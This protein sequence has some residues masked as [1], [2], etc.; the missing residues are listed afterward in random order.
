MEHPYQF[1]MPLIGL[2]TGM[3]I[4]EVCQLYISD[5]K[6]ID[7][8]WCLDINADKPGKSVKNSE[9]RIVPLHSFLI[10]DLNFVG[11]VQ[12]LPDR[13]GRIFPELEWLKDR[14]SRRAGPWFS[15]FKDRC[16]VVAESG[17]KAFHGFRHTVMDHL[18]Q[19]DVPDRTIKMFVGHTITGETGGR[20]GK[21]FEPKLLYEKVVQ[22]LGLR[23]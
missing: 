17:S 20:Y 13:D 6:Q 14:Y 23:S 15:K 11:F 2:Y 7:G 5:L 4:N 1:W 21:R 16:G 8:I 10:D 12:S 18:Y 9:R 19:Q 3:R 22:K